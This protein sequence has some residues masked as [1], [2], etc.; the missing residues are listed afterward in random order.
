MVSG[1]RVDRLAR[2]ALVAGPPLLVAVIV[3]VNAASGLMPGVGFWDTG[4]FQTILPIL[5][6]AHPTGYP[7]YVLLGFVANLLLTPFGE[8][9]YRINLL[10]LLAIAT[11]A[12]ATVVLMRRLTGSLAIAMASGLA[13]ALT[14]D[15]WADATRADPHP[16]HLAFVAILLAVLVIW[17]QRRR[18]GA[19]DADRWLVAAAFVFGLA[20]GNH[21]LTLLLAP[22]IALF[23]LATEPR[24]AF[25][26]KLLLTCAA[27]LAVTL[28]AV[29]LEL[30]LR[31]GPFRAPLV[32][33]RPDTW[34]GFW[35]IALAEQ[36]RG[37]LS[38]PLGDLPR[39]LGMI[40]D[41]ASSQF[42]LATPL[43]LPAFLATIRK[44]PRYALLTGTAMV[45]TLLFNT[46]YSNA[47]ISRYYLGPILWAWSWFGILA[48]FLVELVGDALSGWRMIPRRVAPSVA[49]WL[50][51]ALA[52]ALLVPGIA[53][54][55]TSRRAADRSFDHSA[56]LWLDEALPALAPN[57]VVVSWWS[58]STPLWYAQN[59]EGRR[60]DVF[61][62]DDRTILDLDFGSATGVVDRFFGQRPVYV[63][64]LNDH[65]L[66]LILDHYD[67]TKLFGN[68]SDALYQ[69]VGRKGAT[70]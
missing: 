34:D 60:P 24:I 18:A 38:D 25:R 49:E 41:L 70:G 33:A 29:Y 63:I 69:V 35:Y 53:V 39:K 30:P 7:T 61:I 44:A 8:P 5:G 68:G 2:V 23:V 52:I 58:L 22:P 6:T 67:L 54:A 45:L 15:V 65:D 46:S 27:V 62:V 32:Y 4:E 48:A 1:D 36:F 3:V 10:S 57:A 26:P 37:S 40:G 13:L 12:G 28:V 17:E 42:G 64:R 59:V 11:A 20:V 47:D 66:G 51:V 9:A 43:L 14:P 31:A 56:Q 19:S 16:L 21:S 50:S 55:S